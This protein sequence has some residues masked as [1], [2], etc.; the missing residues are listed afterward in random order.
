M[1]DCLGCGYPYHVDHWMDYVSVLIENPFFWAFVITLFFF[2]ILLFRFVDVVKSN[3]RKADKISSI[4][5]TIRYTE[6]G[7]KKRIDENMELL[8]LFENQCPHVLRKNPWIYG[9]VASQE[10]Y[11]M[12]ISECVDVH[13]YTRSDLFKYETKERHSKFKENQKV[14]IPLHSSNTYDVIDVT[15]DDYVLNAEFLEKLKT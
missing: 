9:W 8:Q 10:K 6:G 3:L 1:N 12:A 5:E 7:I 4:Y 2:T 11:L 14:M 15:K 13:I